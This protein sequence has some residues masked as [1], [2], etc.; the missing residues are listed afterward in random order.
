MS[1]P[2][3][4]HFCN[5]QGAHTTLS[6]SW[7]L[8]KGVSDV[9]TQ[10]IRDRGWRPIDANPRSPTYCKASEQRENPSEVWK[11]TWRAMF[12]FLKNNI[13]PLFGTL[14]NTQGHRTKIQWKRLDRIPASQHAVY[15]HLFRTLRL[16]RQITISQEAF[17]PATPT[18]V[19]G[20]LAKQPFL[21]CQALHG[22][23]GVLSLSSDDPGLQPKLLV[24]SGGASFDTQGLRMKMSQML[25]WAS[26]DMR[27]ELFQSFYKSLKPKVT[28]HKVF[29]C[30][31]LAQ[32]K[33][34]KNAIQHKHI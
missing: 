11:R 30:L 25:V 19:W 23:H 28:N 24:E 1:K 7:A 22:Q 17:H 2:W 29:K 3:G 4:P 5:H 20:I 8:C 33:Y 9:S 10:R 34:C 15:L 27:G 18:E 13:F 14:Q 16:H 21:L 26:E 32:L 31:C 6:T 12:L